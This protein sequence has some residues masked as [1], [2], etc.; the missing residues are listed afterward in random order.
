MIGRFDLST[1][2]TRALP[3]ERV[4]LPVR[5]SR[6]EN[7]IT[8]LPPRRGTTVFSRIVCSFSVSEVD[9]DLLTAT[10]LQSSICLFLPEI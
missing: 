4:L 6:Y 3:T 1:F 10:L 7:Y 5:R 8:D 9:T 2:F